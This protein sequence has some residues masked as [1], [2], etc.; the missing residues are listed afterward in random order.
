MHKIELTETNKLD[1]QQFKKWLTVNW[2][3]CN[4]MVSWNSSS[5]FI[6]FVSGDTYYV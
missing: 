2:I 5:A 3:E 1:K 4:I 6:N